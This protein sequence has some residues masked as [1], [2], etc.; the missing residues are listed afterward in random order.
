MQEVPM[1]RALLKS[2][3]FSAAFA[4]SVAIE[5]REMRVDGAIGTSFRF[6]ARSH[7]FGRFG[8]LFVVL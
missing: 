3:R 2:R 5:R 6:A 7:C 4:K 8:N 1:R